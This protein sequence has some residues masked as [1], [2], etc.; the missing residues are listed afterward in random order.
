[1]RNNYILIGYMGCGKSTI[2]KKMSEILNIKL[3]DTDAWIEERQGMTVSEIFATKGE[4]FFRDLETGALKE[5]LEEKE[6]MVISVGG[7]LPVREENRRLL[8]QLGHVIYLKAEPETIYNRVKG[9]TT[10]PL[11][12]TENPMEKI[13]EMLGQREEKYQVAA[14]KIVTV[15]DKDLSEILDEI[16]EEEKE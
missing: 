2:G 1:M 3:V 8:Q 7:G 4:L 5:L 12:Q 11:L 16:L 13:R 6:L 15:D 9:D 14:D 10:R